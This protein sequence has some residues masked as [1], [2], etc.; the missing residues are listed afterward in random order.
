M[1]APAEEAEGAQI[2]DDAAAASAAQRTCELHA[3]TDQITQ[4][5]AEQNAGLGRTDLFYIHIHQL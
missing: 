5:P 4:V 3:H 2:K 1:R